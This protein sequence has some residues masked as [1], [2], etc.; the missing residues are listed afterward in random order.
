DEMIW[1]WRHYLAKPEDVDHPH[2][3]ILRAP[4]L[5]NLPSATVTS[6]EFDVL[7]DEG[8]EYAERLRAA[9]NQVTL[10][11]VP[12]TCHGYAHLITLAPEA[13]QTAALLGAALR[14]ALA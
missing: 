11:R 5:G 8:E 10:H 13:D 12:N 3:A 6:A 7:R 14:K 9:G 4:D 2:A 1:F